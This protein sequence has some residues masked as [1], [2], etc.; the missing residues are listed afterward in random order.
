MSDKTIL[1]TLRGIEFF[2]GMDEEY[3][4]RLATMARMVEF[5]AHSDIFREN[6]P[7][8][9]IY[10][11]V[12]GRV[13]LVTCLPRVGCR[14]LMEVGNGELISWS[15]LVGRSR[16]SHTAHTLA[17][18]TAL[19]V[20]GEAVLDWCYEDPAFGFEIMRRAVQVLARRL[21]ASRTQ[22]LELDGYRLPE[23][24]LESD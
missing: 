13:S 15:S 9:D 16:L 19:A 5:R 18:T 20:D 21:S 2:H 4:E 22:L 11:I 24:V 17:A 1:E 23:V 3:L 6:D 14:Q 10:L 12:K 8:K 7:P